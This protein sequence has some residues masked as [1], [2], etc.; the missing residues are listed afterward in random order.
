MRFLSL[1][2]AVLVAAAIRAEEPRLPANLTQPTTAYAK[3]T[4]DGKSVSV[5]LKLVEMAPTTETKTV[6]VQQER[7]VDGK[8]VVETVTKKVLVC[9]MKPQRWRE[10]RVDAADKAVSI[11]DASGKP[12]AA[13]KL[14]KLLE[15]D[16][17]VLVSVTGAVDPFHLL[18]VRENTL[19]I[20]APRDLLY[21][22]SPAPL[23]PPK[24]PYTVPTKP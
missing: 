24:G 16:T 5:M 2:A 17:P 21:P 15:K 3:A 8:K 10:V 22:P 20:L 12:I 9:V 18:T 6:N 4:A 14:V 19:V 11:S 13:G 23:A 7:I 1:A